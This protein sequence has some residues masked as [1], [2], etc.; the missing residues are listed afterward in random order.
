MNEIYFISDLHIGAGTEYEEKSKID[1]L[2]AF[3][4]YINHPKNRLYI[5]GDLFDFWFEYKHVI[6][7]KYYRVLFQFYKL[8][9]NGVEVNFVPGNH[10]YWIRNFFHDHVGFIVHPETVEIELQSKK[11]FMFHGDGISTHDKG[12]RLLKKIFRNP[13]NIMLYRWLHPDFGVPLARFMSH[14]SRQ[15]TSNIN[16]NDECDYLNFAIDKFNEGFDCVVV[17][18][19]H[20]PWLKNMNGKYLINL[21]DWISHFSYGLL[22][23]GKLSLRYWNL[24]NNEAKSKKF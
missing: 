2:F 19:S 9:E 22:S 24:N 16:L 20:R 12:Y 15:H 1:K 18:H 4:E 3:L 6:P 23:N 13:I 14:T 8:V 7:K 11:I 10:D 21:G 5:I 17:G